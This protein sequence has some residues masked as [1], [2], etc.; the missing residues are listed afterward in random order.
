[1]TPLREHRGG[2]RRAIL[3]VAVTA[4]VTVAAGCASSDAG[5][6]SSTP[7]SSAAAT[8]RPR[9]ASLPPSTETATT[10][11]TQVVVRPTPEIGPAVV[12]LDQPV[13]LAVRAGD[14]SLYLV[15][16]VGRVIAWRDGV[17]RTVLDIGDA[18]VPEGEQGLLGLAFSPDGERAWINYTDTDGDTVIA[19][20]PVSSDGVFDASRRSIVL[21]IDQPYPN[22][23]G[24]DLAVG[25]DGYLYVGMGDGGSA[26]DPDRRALDVGELLGKVL[27]ID[28]TPTNDQP[29]AVPDD[30]PFASDDSAR[31]E[32]WLRGV[33]NPWRFTFDSLTGDLWIADVGQGEVEEVDA[34]PADDDGLNAGRGVSLG[35]SAFEGDRRFNDDQP[36]DGHVAPLYVY[37]H[38]DGRC[39]ISGGSVYRGSAIAGLD[40]WYLFGDWCSGEVWALEIERDGSFTAGE[41]IDVGSVPGVVNI[42]AGPDGELWALS[43]EGGVFPIVG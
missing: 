18:T 15:E 5:T 13:D 26:N 38:D 42:V 25:P 33:R 29:Y 40:G 20:Y 11:T 22:H 4:A 2:L 27:R 7:S 41:L 24:G 19:E 30:N 9:P 32:V 10:S 3:L 21:T 31:P 36:E 12:E 28:A 35:W 43:T 1:M 34:L 37:T 6:V 39:S 23:N 8:T 16:R 14:D 17:S